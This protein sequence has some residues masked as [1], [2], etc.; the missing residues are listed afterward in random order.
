MSQTICRCSTP[1]RCFWIGKRRFS[2]SASVPFSPVGRH[3]AF[4]LFLTRLR[5]LPV[6]PGSSNL[7]EVSV[8]LLT[9]VLPL[10][11]IHSLYSVK[12]LW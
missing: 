8:A 12:R 6:C 4:Q 10:V 5:L 9:I 11:Y 7:I 3:D 2:L 1:H